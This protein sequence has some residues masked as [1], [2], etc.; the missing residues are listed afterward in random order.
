MNADE[1]LNVISRIS[2]SQPLDLDAELFDRGLTSTK[3]IQ[4]ASHP[5]PPSAKLWES[6]ENPASYIGVRVT[7][8]PADCTQAALRLAGAA[9]ER[10]VIPIILTTLPDSGFERFGFRVERLTG[11]SPQDYRQLEEQLM[12]F[13]DMAIVIDVEQ[14]VQLG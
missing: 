10:G 4:P 5:T 9:S 13:W 12:R 14:V 7:K 3:N 1:W 8:R 6:G 2:H 11:D